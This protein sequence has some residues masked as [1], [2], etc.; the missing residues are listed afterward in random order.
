MKSIQILFTEYFDRP[1]IVYAHHCY[2]VKALALY[3]HFSQ[4]AIHKHHPQNLAKFLAS[5]FPLASC[6]KP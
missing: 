1:G 6:S 4:E 3:H 2:S 5:V